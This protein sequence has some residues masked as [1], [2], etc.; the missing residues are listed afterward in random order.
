MADLEAAVT[1]VVVTVCTGCFNDAETIVTQLENAKAPPG[2]R[3]LV[4]SETCT[5]K[6]YSNGCVSVSVSNGEEIH[7]CKMPSLTNPADRKLPKPVTRLITDV[8]KYLR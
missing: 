4:E 1:E 5:R 3:V 2:Y 7:Y 8:D 6:C